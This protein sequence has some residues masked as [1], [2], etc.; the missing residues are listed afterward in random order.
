MWGITLILALDQIAAGTRLLAAAA[1]QQLFS[2]I[3]RGLTC[4]G[5]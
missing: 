3:P 4:S 5:G 1:L 2:G